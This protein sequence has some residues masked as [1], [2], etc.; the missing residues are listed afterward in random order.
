MG[1]EGELSADAGGRCAAAA[2][3]CGLAL[4]ALRLCL[5]VH[6][7]LPGQAPDEAQ[8]AALGLHLLLPR[9]AR[10]HRQGG[11][12]GMGPGER[13]PGT[14]HTA[15]RWE[16]VAVTCEPGNKVAGSVCLEPPRN[17]CSVTVT[18]PVT[19]RKP[20]QRPAHGGRWQL[21]LRQAAPAH[22][23]VLAVL[24]HLH[25][26]RGGTLP[27]SWKSAGHSCTHAH[28]PATQTDMHISYVHTLI[29]HSDAHVSHIDT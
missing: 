18:T 3:R 4:P 10:G 9:A 17:L 28:V 16:T 27:S 15:P 14:A 19:D 6:L 25:G 13:C 1:Q 21:G 29:V 22:P 24:G 20:C 26:G 12:G 11:P 23:C 8:E 5:R 2:Q 7:R